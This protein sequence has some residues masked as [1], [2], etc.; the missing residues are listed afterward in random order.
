MTMIFIPYHSPK[1]TVDLTQ[2]DRQF[3]AALEAKREKMRRI[4][5]RWVPALQFITQQRPEMHWCAYDD[6]RVVAFVDLMQDEAFGDLEPIY[7]F[8][9]AQVRHLKSLGNYR[10]EFDDAPLPDDDTECRWRKWAFKAGDSQLVINCSFSM[11]ASCRLVDDG[12]ETVEVV[13]RRVV[14]EPLISDATIA[15]VEAW[16]RYDRHQATRPELAEG[17]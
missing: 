1:G 7:D 12:T 2:A 14:C 10:G 4:V 8:C 11:S 3:A 16:D 6:G 9:A 13:K 5:T 15:H 17:V